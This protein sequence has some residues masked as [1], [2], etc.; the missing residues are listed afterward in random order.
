MTKGMSTW[1]DEQLLPTHPSSQLF[2]R[3]MYGHLGMCCMWVSRRT[4]KQTDASSKCCEARDIIC[5]L[6]ELTLIFRK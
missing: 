5:L 6:L 2:S 3:V 1:M 4:I